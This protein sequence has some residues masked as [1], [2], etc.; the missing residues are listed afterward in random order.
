MFLLGSECNGLRVNSN[1]NKWMV[2]SLVLRQFTRSA[3]SA[4]ACR[5]ALHLSSEPLECVDSICPLGVLHT[6]TLS[7]SAQ[8]ETVCK[9]VNSMLGAIRRA[10][11][12]TN[13]NVPHCL[14]TAFIMPRLLYCLPV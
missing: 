12:G 11:N 8:V 7:W 4:T 3:G 14:F 9:K 13:A 5:S 1:K 6:D 10:R 2:I